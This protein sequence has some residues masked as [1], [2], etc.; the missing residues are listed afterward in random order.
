[1]QSEIFRARRPMDHSAKSLCG[2]GLKTP[3]NTYEKTSYLGL[4]GGVESS[5]WSSERLEAV[6]LGFWAAS[7]ATSWGSRWGAEPLAARLPLTTQLDFEPLRRF[8]SVPHH[9]DM[10]TSR[11]EWL[12]TEV[13]CACV[14]SFHG[15][16][17][18][19]RRSRTVRSC[20]AGRTLAG[21][22]AATERA[23]V[24]CCASARF[25]LSIAKQQRDPFSRGH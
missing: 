7:E 11:V 13:V 22:P 9:R 15:S 14:S 10:S 3:S 25:V 16:M 12:G 8:V 1:M 20:S 6:L 5:L 18:E 23:R 24:A 2:I 19:F 21:I 4:L 17:D